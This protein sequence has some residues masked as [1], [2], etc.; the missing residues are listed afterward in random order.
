VSCPEKCSL[1]GGSVAIL[2][3]TGVWVATA[4]L[5]SVG[6]AG[7]KALYWAEVELPEVTAEG[8]HNWSAEFLPPDAS[9]QAVV[10]RPSSFRFS[11]QAVKP[12]EHRVTV[13][14][15]E[16]QTANPIDGVELRLGVYKARSDHG[17]ATFEVPSGT[18][19][20]CLWKTG[21]DIA[22]ISVE[23]KGNVTVDVG[24]SKSAAVEEPYWM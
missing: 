21:H 20:L 9:L 18:Y 15:V 4:N 11:F 16:E 14:I 6:L 8:P 12:P 24:L 19:E 2:D 3:E 7:T 5:R 23:V 17:I 13:R 1:A 22:S 10:H